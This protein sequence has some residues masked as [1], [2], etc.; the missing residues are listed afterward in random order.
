MRPR[1]LLFAALLLAAG[2]AH[3]GAFED[4]REM[5]RDLSVA[6]WTGDALWFEQN[7]ADEYVLIAPNGD[8]R[9]KREFIRELT[10]SGLKMDPYEPLDV[11]VRIYG[12]SAVV[13]GRLVQRFTIAGTRYA[14]DVRYTDVYV[15]GKKGWQLVSGHSSAITGKK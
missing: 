4:I 8:V 10:T 3:A 14:R 15:K 2:T 1:S 9:T 5:N 7:M 11:H 6:T 12:G 13:T